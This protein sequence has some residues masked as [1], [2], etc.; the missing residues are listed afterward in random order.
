[1]DIVEKSTAT[2]SA[3]WDTSKMDIDTVKVDFCQ[4]WG[5]YKMENGKITD[6]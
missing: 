2:W 4:K 6:L 5:L 3:I 1:M